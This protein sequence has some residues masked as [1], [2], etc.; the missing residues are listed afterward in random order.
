MI[1]MDGWIN[2]AVR[3]A[4]YLD[5]MLLFGLPLFGL[6]ALRRHERRST[7][8]ARP[9]RALLAMLVAVG[10]ALSVGSMIVMGKAMTGASD[11]ASIGAHAISMLISGTAFGAAW[12]VRIA[13]LGACF[14]ALLALARRPTTALAVATVSGGIALITLA[15]GGHGV[16]DEGDKG[17][18]HLTSDVFHLIAAAGWVGALTAFGLLLRVSHSTPK[19]RIA[20]L[21]RT[22]NSFAVVGAMIVVTLVATGLINYGMI[23]GPT[24]SGLFTTSYGQLLVVK[25][26]LFGLMLGLAAAN[27]YHLAPLL[28]IRVQSGDYQGA[29]SALRRS[30]FIE[31]NAATAILAVV[32]AL[33][34]LSPE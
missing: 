28:E 12:L 9:L 4:L 10:M 11:Y 23:V 13:A 31:A 24:L 33:G 6:Y 17:I 19:A 29:I 15:W 25:L 18:L 16:M 1:G 7:Y 20:L 8:F 27:R 5:L 22:L 14:A 26:A 34:T 21:S 3:F 32:A 30:L 2:I